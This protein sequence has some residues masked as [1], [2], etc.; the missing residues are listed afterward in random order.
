MSSG[1][2]FDDVV[3]SGDIHLVIHYCVLSSLSFVAWDIPVSVLWGISSL[4]IALG[5][6]T[7]SH[8]LWNDSSMSVS[9]IARFQ[10]SEPC[11]VIRNWE[12]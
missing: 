12:H 1:V 4:V 11:S 3:G 7:P 6:N 9:L 10:Q 2:H 8:I 5:R